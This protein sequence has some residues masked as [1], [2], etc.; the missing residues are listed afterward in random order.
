[1]FTVNRQLGGRSRHGSVS[2]APPGGAPPS[3]PLLLLLRP[4]LPGPARARGPHPAG[5][6]H[7]GGRPGGADGGR[8]A[9]GRGPA[10]AEAAG[11]DEGGLP[12]GRALLQGQAP[13]RGQ[14]RVLSAPEDAQRCVWVP[15]YPMNSHSV[16][17]IRATFH[18]VSPTLSSR[19]GPPRPRPLHGR[20]GLAGEER[21]LPPRLLHVRHQRAL[22]PLH[23]LVPVAQGSA[24]LL[25]LD[26]AGETQGRDGQR[27]RAGQQ[28]IVSSAGLTLM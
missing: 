26:P 8:E 11:A 7:A 9:A 5:D 23:L 24:R 16:N 3:P 6:L 20:R 4:L 27:H 2:A 1:M 21:H 10:Q 28:V 19:C 12:P 17:I 18:L 13:H 22:P 25:R 15:E 14:S